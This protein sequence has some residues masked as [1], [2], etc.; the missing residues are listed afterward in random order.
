MKSG[1]ARGFP[2]RVPFTLIRYF[3]GLV[4]PVVIALSLVTIVALSTSVSAR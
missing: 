2:R 1:N 3:R 4:A